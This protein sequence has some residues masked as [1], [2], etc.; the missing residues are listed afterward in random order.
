MRDAYPTSFRRDNVQPERATRRGL[1]PY[2]LI[3]IFDG[4]SIQDLVRF[5]RMQDEHVVE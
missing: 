2:F 3:G 4:S 1:A 5:V